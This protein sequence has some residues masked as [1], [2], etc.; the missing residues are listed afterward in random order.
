MKRG[1]TGIPLA[2][3]QTPCLLLDEPRMRRNILRLRERLAKFPVRFRPHLK[4]SKCSQVALALMDTPEG[5]AA[6]STLLEAERF[7]ESGVRDIIY[8]VGIA[9]QNLTAEENRIHRFGHPS[10]FIQ[11]FTS[12]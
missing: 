8:A 10:V 4:T 5:P 6:V 11:R 1:A 12:G 3:L 9:S 2:Q 7:A